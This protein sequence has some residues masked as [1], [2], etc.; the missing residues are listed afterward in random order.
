VRVER[1]SLRLQTGET[2]KVSGG[3]RSWSGRGGRVQPRPGRLL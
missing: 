1:P 3:I 2:T